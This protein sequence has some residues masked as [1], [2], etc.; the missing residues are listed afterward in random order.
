MI[1]AHLFPTSLLRNT[2]GIWSTSIALSICGAMLINAGLLRNSYVSLESEGHR[3]TIPPRSWKQIL[4]EGR[5]THIHGRRGYARGPRD[6]ASGLH[7]LSRSLGRIIVPT[8]QGPPLSNRE[9]A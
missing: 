8:R 7:G 6:M 5:E 3:M 1:Y 9:I 4:S 2:S